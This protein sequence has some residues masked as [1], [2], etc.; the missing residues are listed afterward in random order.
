MQGFDV[1]KA[2][3]RVG[4]ILAVEKPEVFFPGKE[5]RRVAARGLLCYRA[6]REPGISQSLLAQMLKIS[7]AAATACVRRGER[8][9][10]DRGYSSTLTR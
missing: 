10:K 8:V 9:A 1:R 5:R 6:A 4:E 2:A 7:P 3:D